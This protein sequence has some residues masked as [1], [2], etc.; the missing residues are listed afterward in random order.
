[1][2]KLTSL[3]SNGFPAKFHLS[4]EDRKNV[5]VGGLPDPAKDDFIN[6]IRTYYDSL[7]DVEHPE[8][9][10]INTNLD[11]QRYY[12]PI[13]K[14]APFEEITKLKKEYDKTALRFTGDL[15]SF[16]ISDVKAA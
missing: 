11:V 12:S 15:N 3:K 13:F 6:V 2:D 8:A 4:F 14:G 16:G 5:G 7:L 9:D 10:S 1:M